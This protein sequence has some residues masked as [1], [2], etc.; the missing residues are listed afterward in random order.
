M[1]KILNAAIENKAS[2]IHIYPNMTG[3]SF[4]KLRVMG[5]LSKYEKFRKRGLKF[6]HGLETSGY[7]LRLTCGQACPC[8]CP[9]P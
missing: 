3:Y 9:S 8:P 5:N 7:G 4:I 2:D 1:T 6:H